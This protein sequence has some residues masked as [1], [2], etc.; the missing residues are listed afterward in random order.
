MKSFSFFAWSAGITLL[1]YL[2]GAM[3]AL[4]TQ[5]LTF[6][7]FAAAVAIPLSG[8]TGWAAKAATVPAPE[9]LLS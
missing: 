4:F 8:M 5:G 1:V 9:K 7:E 2:G 3:Y 6:G